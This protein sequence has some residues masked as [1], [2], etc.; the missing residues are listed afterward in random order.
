MLVARICNI[1]YRPCVLLLFLEHQWSTEKV[2]LAPSVGCIRCKCCNV[3]ELGDAYA[4]LSRKAMSRR[5]CS[6]VGLGMG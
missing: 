6:T 5:A 2:R 3:L 4:N 1:H